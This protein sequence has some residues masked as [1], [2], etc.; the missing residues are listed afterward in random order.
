ME[1]RHFVAY[2]L[3]FLLT[4]A[5]VIGYRLLT[6]DSRGERRLERLAERGRKRRRDDRRRDEAAP[7]FP[8][9]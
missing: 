5:L 4:V 3:I 1:P 6:R 7:D 2:G 8:A 9:G